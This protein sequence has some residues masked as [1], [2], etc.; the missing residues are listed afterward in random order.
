[1]VIL[2]VFGGLIAG[3]LLLAGIRTIVVGKKSSHNVV[4][5]H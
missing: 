4:S 2:G 3:A 1:M 5:L